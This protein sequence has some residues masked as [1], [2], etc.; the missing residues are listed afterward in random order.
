MPGQLLEDRDRGFLGRGQARPADDEGL[1]E[2]I[3]AAQAGVAGAVGEDDPG[4]AG[5]KLPAVFAAGLL[6]TGVFLHGVVD[7][8]HEAVVRRTV[9]DRQAQAGRGPHCQVL[10]VVQGARLPMQPDPIRELAGQRLEVVGGVPDPRPLRV[11][12]GE[13][14]QQA[15]AVRRPR[16]K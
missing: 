10:P 4:R 13:N 15:V 8:E 1:L 7:L 6:K 16:R 9:D 2:R 12:V 3:L 14:P 11:D 5:G